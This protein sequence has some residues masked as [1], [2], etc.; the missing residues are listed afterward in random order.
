MTIMCTFS[1]GID[2]VPVRAK[3]FD[4][5]VINILRKQG[6]FSVFEASANKRIADVMTRLCS[7][8]G[9][10]EVDNSTGFPWTKIVSIDGIK[11]E[12]E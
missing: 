12:A 10:L 1:V 3:D 2:E 11:L 4:E 8:G 5:Q 7:D 6:R 9:R